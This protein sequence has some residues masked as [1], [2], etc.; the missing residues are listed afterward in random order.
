MD[1]RIPLKQ[2]ASIKEDID[3]VYFRIK[4]AT[5]EALW[6]VIGCITDSEWKDLLPTNYYMIKDG[7][8]WFI[9]PIKQWKP[10]TKEI[11]NI[12][13]SIISTTE[14]LSTEAYHI[15]ESLRKD[16]TFLKE[17]VRS[18]IEKIKIITNSFID[19]R[20]S[21]CQWY[22]IYLKELHIL[23]EELAR[24]KNSLAD[25][26]ST[27][28]QHRERLELPLSIEQKDDKLIELTENFVDIDR[29]IA[30]L[31]ERLSILKEEIEALNKQLEYDQQIVNI[32]KQ[33]NSFSRNKRKKRSSWK[34]L[35]E[36]DERIMTNVDS[37]AEKTKEKELLERLMQTCKETK[38]FFFN[39]IL[40]HKVFKTRKLKWETSKLQLQTLVLDNGQLK[41]R[42]SLSDIEVRYPKLL[43]ELWEYNKEIERVEKSIRQI[44]KH[45][46]DIERTLK[47]VKDINTHQSHKKKQ[48]ELKGKIE[49]LQKKATRLKEWYQG[50]E[51]E[52]K[53][54]DQQKDMSEWA[55]KEFEKE[56]II[57]EWQHKKLYDDIIATIKAYR[58]K[59]SPLSESDKENIELE[60][61]RVRTK[62]PHIQ[63]RI[64]KLVICSNNKKVESKDH[65][66]RINATSNNLQESLEEFITMGI[67]MY[68]SHK[69]RQNNSKGFLPDYMRTYIHYRKTIDSYTEQLRPHHIIWLKELG[70]FFEQRE[71]EIEEEFQTLL[72]QKFTKEKE[73]QDL[74]Y[75]IE[76][77][78]DEGLQ[79][80]HNQRLYTLNTT[81]EKYEWEKL[82][83]EREKEKIVNGN[84][85]QGDE[86]TAK[87][88]QLERDYISAN[89]ERE[90]I[91]NS[92]TYKRFKARIQSLKDQIKKIEQEIS[93]V[94]K[95]DDAENTNSKGCL[96]YKIESCKL[97][98]EF[99]NI[100]SG[101]YENHKRKN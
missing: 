75:E 45:I 63:E 25:Y 89:K 81:I 64:Q 73:Q 48:E 24:G 55:I 85:I 6:I 8:R 31:E 82:R 20:D 40:N 50:K 52:K 72:K 42:E 69:K 66:D 11:I 91:K 61:A 22:K 29:N 62:I 16:F 78:N 101:E 92:D 3:C 79:K 32:L 23:E 37:I 90:G 94:N 43:R 80:N 12:M 18:D 33:D 34:T 86:V 49:G 10:A 54:L 35:I 58:V 21:A 97:K 39:K 19:Q 98:K 71:R 38:N 84:W 17:S 67:N 1:W 5:K 30:T 9:P 28:N 14:W 46:N 60:I 74:Q 51:N 65:V 93:E 99:L 36:T 4:D 96:R 41:R 13:R 57:V 100:L 77:L 56:K 15:V 26:Q 76:I 70:Y 47:S 27:L 44:E 87:L 7:E 95:E 53:S 68:Q 59:A 88:E 83:L 2:G